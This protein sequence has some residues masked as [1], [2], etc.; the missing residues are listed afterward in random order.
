[1]K[2][3]VFMRRL[4]Q[5]RANDKMYNASESIASAIS[6]RLHCASAYLDEIMTRPGLAALNRDIC[7]NA[8]E[9][10]ILHTNVWVR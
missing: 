1:M 5:L 8:R 9:P 2:V 4:N 6:Q 7:S 3:T 10:T